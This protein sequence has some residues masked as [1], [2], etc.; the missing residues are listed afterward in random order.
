MIFL[1]SYERFLDQISSDKSHISH[2]KSH[3][4]WFKSHISQCKSHT[5]Q[6]K[7]HIFISQFKYNVSLFESHLSQFKPH[8]IHFKSHI[9]QFESHIIQFSEIFCQFI[10][11]SR[12]VF[13][14]V[15]PCITILNHDVIKIIKCPKCYICV[16]LGVSNLV[17]SQSL[18]STQT[19]K[20]RWNLDNI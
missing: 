19:V 7:S 6:F 13:G 18:K 14:L 10:S 15:Y 5:S 17:A 8:L 1:H 4:S 3:M 12:T 16:N 2:F 20:V 11:Q 9:S